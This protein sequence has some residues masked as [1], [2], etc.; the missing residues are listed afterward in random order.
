MKDNE[1]LNDYYLTGLVRWTNWKVEN[2]Q[3]VFTAYRADIVVF[4]HREALCLSFS[5]FKAYLKRPKR[6]PFAAN[7]EKFSQGIILDLY[8]QNS[9]YLSMQF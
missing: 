1:F 9:P 2:M 6:Q 7:C 3:K 8:Y 5:Q 4:F